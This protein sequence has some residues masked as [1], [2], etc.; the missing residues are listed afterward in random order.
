M[1]CPQCDSDNFPGEDYCENC[2]TDLRESDLFTP[3]G[4][5]AKVLSDTITN[6]DPPEPLV[7]NS[8]ATVK[9]AVELMKTRGH[10]SVI[11]VDEGK[12]NGIFTERDL[13]KRVVSKGLEAD[14][15]IISKVMTKKVQTLKETDSIAFA[16]NRMSIHSIRH[17]PIMRK[18]KP[19]G[20][21]S[22]RGMLKYLAEHT[23]EKA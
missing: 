6:L 19:V 16:L 3:E 9:D 7:V 12:F 4:L 23:L 11:I 10:G 22:V 8:D 21:I 20:I 18:N 13:L 2:G 14:S 1:R 15:V 5:G 17:I